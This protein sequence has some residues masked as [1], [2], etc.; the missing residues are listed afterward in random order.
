[1]LAKE[2]ELETKIEEEENDLEVIR[3][4]FDNIQEEYEYKTEKLQNIWM[5]CQQ[6]EMDLHQVSDDFDRERND[7]YDTIY[8]LTN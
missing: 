3:K 2:A 5:R 1:V 6:A 4:K 7:M 8:E